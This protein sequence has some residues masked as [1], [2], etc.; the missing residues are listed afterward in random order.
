MLYL[1]WRY[2]NE[3]PYALYNLLDGRY[4]PWGG[5]EP[6]PPPHP[7]RLV[8]FIYGCAEVAAEEA[9]M[10]AGAQAGRKV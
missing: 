1:A 3:N 5:G 7:A 6:M 9:R 4:V 2:G 8:A 10:L